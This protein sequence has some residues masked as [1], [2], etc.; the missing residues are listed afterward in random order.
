MFFSKTYYLFYCLLKNTSRNV[1]R[2]ILIY[3][4]NE[5]DKNIKSYV[6]HSLSVQLDINH[7]YEG[8]MLRKK[9]VTN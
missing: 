5:R 7:T 4:M 2:H 9:T 3:H 1:C 8:A 6:V